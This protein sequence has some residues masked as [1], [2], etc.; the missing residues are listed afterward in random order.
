MQTL[1]YKGYIGSV[2]MSLEDDCLH[3]RVQFIDDI[4][5]YEGATPVELK[6]AFEDAVARYLAYCEKTGKPANKSFSGSFNVRV[7]A[8][9]HRALAHAAMHRDVAIN[10]VVCQAVDQFLAPSEAAMH[11]HVHIHMEAAA[12]MQPLLAGSG[13]IRSLPVWSSSQHVSHKH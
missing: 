3:G 9:R 11:N 10:E 5:S 4:I 12:E 7:G 8:D 6:R 1:A 2:D 13:A